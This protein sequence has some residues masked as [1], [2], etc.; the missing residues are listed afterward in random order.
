MAVK[1][2]TPADADFSA[3]GDTEWERAHAVDD[4]SFVAA[5][6]S[7][8]AADIVF[9]RATAGAGNGE[10]IA[11]TAAGRAILDDASAAAQRTTLGAGCVMQF[12]S[13][14]V[15]NPADGATYFIG[16]FVGSIVAF[17]ASNIPRIPIPKAGTVVRID[18]HVAV[19]GTLGTTEQATAS[20][21]L[22]N[23]TDTT[24]SAAVQFNAISQFF[25]SGVVSVAVVA[26]DY[27]EIKIV[28]PT[29]VT[30]PTSV[31]INGSV[32]IE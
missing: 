26:G 18:M 16:P 1:H 23:T 13:S 7:A 24:I 5:K 14:S 21:R 25:T 19:G 27:F 6:L 29:F 32:Y 31:V 22:N 17:T 12:G 15:G 9:G 28:M 20:F 10:E 2:Q 30:N 8:T 4:G 3:T 11:V